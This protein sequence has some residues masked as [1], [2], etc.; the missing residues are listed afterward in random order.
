MKTKKKAGP[1]NVIKKLR[2]F[3]K[4]WAG[5]E[6]VDTPFGHL[7]VGPSENGPARRTKKAATKTKTA[8]SGHE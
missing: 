1:A 7:L 6:G 3:R 2:Q 8:E 4:R 5:H